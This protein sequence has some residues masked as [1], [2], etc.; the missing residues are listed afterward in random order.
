MSVATAEGDNRAEAV[1]EASLH[2]PL[3]DH[4]LISGARNIL[5]NISVANAEELMYEEV[6]RILEYIQAHASVE[7]ESGNIHNDNISLGYE[8]ETP[9]WAMPSSWWWWRR[10][11]RATRRSG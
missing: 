11:S 7:D 2:S 3:L 10:D 6:V 8:R 5:L 4:N 1:A 9:S